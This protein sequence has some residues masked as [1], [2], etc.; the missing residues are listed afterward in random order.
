MTGFVERV[1]LMQNKEYQ[2]LRNCPFCGG[3]AL[4]SHDHAGIGASY[5]RCEK[6]GLESIRFYQSFA[7]ASDEKAVEYWNR[8]AGD[9]DE[10]TTT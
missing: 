4:L 7:H 1:H 8:R 5:V 3:K 2:K 6:C 10:N 9:T